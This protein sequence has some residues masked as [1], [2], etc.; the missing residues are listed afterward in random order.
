MTVDEKDDSKKTQKYTV[1]AEEVYVEGVTY[2][3]IKGRATQENNKLEQIEYSHSNYVKEIMSER[4]FL[5]FDVFSLLNYGF[6][7][8]IFENGIDMEHSFVKNKKFSIY[9]NNEESGTTATKHYI[10][11]VESNTPF[12][13]GLKL[14]YKRTHEAEYQTSVSKK[15]E[16]KPVYDEIIAYKLTVN[17]SFFG[18]VSRPRDYHKYF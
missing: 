6:F 17:P 5:G 4:S 10:G 8:K 7:D 15:G 9:N 2:T 12:I 18:F 16:E 3:K 13:K 1:K 14:F 11:Q